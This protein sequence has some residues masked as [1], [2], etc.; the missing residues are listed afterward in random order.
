MVVLYVGLGGAQFL[1]ILSSPG[2]SLPFMLVSALICLAMV[3]TLLSSQMT[4][5][6]VVPRAV[7]FRELNRLSPLGVAAVIVAGVI[8]PLL[9]SVGPGYGRL[10]GL[11]TTA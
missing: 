4:P 6:V 5:E 10:Q 11:G 8:S 2:T 9:F 7:P 1:L 3:P